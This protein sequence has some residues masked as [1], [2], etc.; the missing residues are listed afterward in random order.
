MELNCS[1]K[2]IKWRDKGFLYHCVIKNASIANIN[3][4]IT[5]SGNHV[6][7]KT[8]EDVRVIKFENSTVHYFPIGLAQPFSN[9]RALEMNRCGLKRIT[10]DDLKGFEM[11]N[12]I[13]FDGNE[14][15]YLPGDLLSDFKYLKEVSFHGNH[16]KYIGAGFLDN[17]QLDYAAFRGNIN[18]NCFYSKKSESPSEKGFVESYNIFMSQLNKCIPAESIKKQYESLKPTPASEREFCK[19]K[20]FETLLQSGRLTDLTIK[21][22]GESF[23]LHKFVLGARSATFA[24]M[25]ESN[26]DAKEL[27]L[28]NI[29]KETFKVIV[30]FIYKDDIPSDDANFLELYAATGK[31]KIEELMKMAEEK[32]SENVNETNFLEILTVANIYNSWKLKEKSV[33]FVHEMFPDFEDSDDALMDRPDLVKEMFDARREFEEKLDV[34]KNKL[35]LKQGG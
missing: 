34:I 26:E 25:F 19:F 18:I 11:L 23:K 31:L 5:I 12:D 7:G 27:K 9:L 13:F 29:N 8:N 17:V 35:K 20:A 15:E 3:T 32:L 21:I 14:L 33:A 4:K 30:D 22:D 2:L 16:I 10:K 1:Y 24:E 6:C 28:S